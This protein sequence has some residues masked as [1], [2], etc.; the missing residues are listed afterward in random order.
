MIED[1]T[2][3][4][5]SVILAFVIL[6]VLTALVTW[7]IATSIA[8]G[9]ILAYIFYPIYTKIVFVV[10]E[11]NISA[12]LTILLVTF[13]VFL[14]VWI[15][16]PMLLKQIF[17]FYLFM[18]TFDIFGLIQKLFPALIQSGISQ[19]IAASLNSFISN[20]VSATVLSSNAITTSTHL[21]SLSILARSSIGIK[22]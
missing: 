12:I 9:L 5:L 3:K 13:I 15:F 17:D 11:K 1:N 7:Q 2:F 19:D 6:L 4:K 10:R 14:P 16:L 21:N 20:I 22:T 18:Q 8:T